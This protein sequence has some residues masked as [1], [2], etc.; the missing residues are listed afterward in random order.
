M[1]DMW[2][3]MICEIWRKSATPSFLGNKCTLRWKVRWFDHFELLKAIGGDEISDNQ[4]A[5][6]PH[7][8][9]TTKEGSQTRTEKDVLLLHYCYYY[10]YYYYYY[11]ALNRKVMYLIVR[12]NLLHCTW[13]C[14]TETTLGQST[15][16]LKRTHCT[17]S[18]HHHPDLILQAILEPKMAHGKNCHFSDPTFFQTWHILHALTFIATFITTTFVISNIE[19][20][21]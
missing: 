16:Q 10:Y 15:L 6:P 14:C 12:W 8:I 19:Y 7:S 21:W 13:Q 2:C 3:H 1:W 17:F 18:L 11:S 9:V 5:R 4:R 20:M